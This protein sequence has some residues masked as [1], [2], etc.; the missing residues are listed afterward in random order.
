MLLRSGTRTEAI[1]GK[2]GGQER[3]KLKTT[4]WNKTVALHAL[5]EAAGTL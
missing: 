2:K 1:R 4:L 3:R 5:L